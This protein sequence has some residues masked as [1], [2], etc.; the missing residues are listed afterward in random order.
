MDAQ[1]TILKMIGNWTVVLALPPLLGYVIFY[2]TRS[3]W[4]KTPIGIS[5]LVQKVLLTLLVIVIVIGLYWPDMPGREVIRLVIFVACV[6]AFW[7]DFIQ[8][9]RIQ[10]QVRHP[11]KADPPATQD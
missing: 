4:W 3:P 7:W 11:A 10:Y 5:M 1:D 6:V 2:S 8:A 9:L